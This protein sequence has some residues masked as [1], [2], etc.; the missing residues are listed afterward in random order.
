MTTSTCNLAAS[1]LNIQI[2]YST[3]LQHLQYFKV[4]IN[5]TSALRHHSGTFKDSTPEAII[6]GIKNT[7][8]IL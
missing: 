7:V 2:M 8:I 1:Q 4:L 5:L 6:R 3:K